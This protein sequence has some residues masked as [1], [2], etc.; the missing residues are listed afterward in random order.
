MYE[1]PNCAGNLKYDIPSQ[2]L[3]CQHC[4]TKT[5][6]YNY[7]KE[8]D[9]E[10]STEYDV[11]VFR[12]PQCAG[13]ILS[14][15]ET[16]ATFC[17]FCGASTI[18]DSRLSKEK[19]PSKI[20]PFTKTKMDCIFSYMAQAKKMPF[21]PD[22]LL[23]DKCVNSFRGI[24]MPYWSYDIS[25][26]GRITF[27]TTHTKTTSD[28]D[29]ISDYTISGDL[30]AHYYG[31]SHDASSSFAD[32][33]S[34]YM[35]P[36]DLRKARKFTPA[37]LSGF[38]ADTYDIQQEKYERQAK[39]MAAENTF[40]DILRHARLKNMTLK[41]IYDDV[42][43]THTVLDHAELN[44]FPVW[45]MSYRKKDRIAY[46]TVNGQSGDVLAD[47][48]ID[49]K[50]FFKSSAIYSLVIF[51][52]LNLFFTLRPIVTLVIAAV[53]SLIAIILY[54]TELSK[55]K[56][57]ELG[58]IPAKMMSGVTGSFLSII[59]AI[60]VIILNPVNDIYYYAAVIF[61]LC[62]IITTLLCTIR[63]YNMLSTRPLP[64]FETHKGGDDN[65]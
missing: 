21:V 64:Q 9:A 33:I 39:K 45:F 28:Y 20:I 52:L 3:M 25:Q 56:K 40:S 60:L 30:D 58:H 61:C 17:S 26:K 47:Y 10:E 51:L 44:L 22:D 55:I 46:A 4:G 62:G 12:C 7:Y 6:P 27:Q 57:K 13:E 1:C 43:E 5:D 23:D 49:E 50:K 34:E 53:I 14:T 59:V 16:A 2:Q 19:K 24:Y 42:E 54:I 15:D 65:A 37:F 41:P 31:F 48:P 38:Y 63:Y 35:D 8:S 18:L 29:I 32:S 36:F 11:T